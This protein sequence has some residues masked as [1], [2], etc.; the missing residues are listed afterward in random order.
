M[1]KQFLSLVI[2][3]TLFSSISSTTSVTAQGTAVP[4][5]AHFI[6]LPIVTTGSWSQQRDG[7]SDTAVSTTPATIN[8]PDFN[9]DGCADLVIGAHQEY[10]IEENR[11][12]QVHIMYGSHDGATAVGSQIWH[13]DGG[14]DQDGNY[15]GDIQDDTRGHD[16]FGQVV[17]TGD[18]NMDGYTDL[19]IG[20]PLAE[21]DGAV[22]T[23]AVHVLHGSEMG[24]TAVN[25]QLWTQDG[26]WVDPEGDGTGVYLGDI[27]G[28]PED[29]DRFGG[30]LT[31]GDFNG[32]NYTDLAI[33]VYKE[34]IGST[35]AAGAVNVLFGSEAGLTWINNQFWAQ[36]GGW[37]EDNGTTHYNHLGDVL[38]IVEA[39]D[40]FGHALAAGDLDNDGYDELIVG[41]YG[42]AIGSLSD[43][44]AVSIIKGSETGLTAVGNQHWHQ[45]AAYLDTDGNGTNDLL[46]GNPSGTEE[47][48]DWFGY[49][50]TTGDFNGDG[51]ADLAVG[52][53]RE[54]LWIDGIEYT[55]NGVAQVFYGSAT[56]LTLVNEQFWQQN[57]EY[58]L[59]YYSGSTPENND[60]FGESL[61]AG[62]ING[63]GFGDLVVGA[64][65]ESFAEI[66]SSVGSVNVIYGATSGLH[67]P[68]QQWLYQDLVIE[69]GFVIGSL[70]GEA[71]SNSNF[72]KAMTL[73]DLNKDGYDELIV[74][75]PRHELDGDNVGA[76]NII[77]G[78]HAGLIIEG[79]QLWHQ[80]GGWDDQGNFLGDLYGSAEDD[81]YFGGSLP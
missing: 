55:N 48:G 38:G 77:K 21:V 29:D 36:D 35:D 15:L 80:N 3:V 8:Q 67:L 63:D 5:C 68:E 54:D 9:G 71:A 13:R 79:N 73:A 53:P 14:Y 11:E 1:I 45:Q 17:A 33:G 20:V 40:L 7:R 61:A 57:G 16:H 51:Y 30:T 25:N 50:L 75:V 6:Y 64:P 76:I 56:G 18:F 47:S 69:E 27:Y 2:L 22:N 34:D 58:S 66:G 19:A 46:I 59:G 4:Q 32:D 31:T 81:D 12:G 52:V 72:G 60:Y 42:E 44:G 49:S 43:A 39:D 26:G 24:L 78:S 65:G 10:A 23:G 74:G 28:G 70:V 41:A 62:D 37:A